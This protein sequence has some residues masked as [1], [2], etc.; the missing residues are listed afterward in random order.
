MNGAVRVQHLGKAYALVKPG[1]RTWW[2]VLRG[3]PQDDAQRRWVLRDVSFALRPG[4]SVGIIGVNGAGKSTLLKL[5]VGTSLPSQGEV[6]CHGRVV[7]M[8]E[9]G[10]GFHPEFSGREN[11]F[12]A[13]QLLGHSRQELQDRLQA[14]I[15][16]AELQ[17][18]I[19][20]PLRVYSSGMQMRLAFSVATALRP[21]VLIIDEALSVG[22]VAFQQKC[23]DRIRAFKQ[24]G[25]TL[26]LVSHDKNAVTQVCDRVLL[27]NHGAVVFDG[28]PVPAFDLYNALLAQHQQDHQVPQE[29]LSAGRGLVSGTGEAV[30]QQAR[31]CDA[32][33]GEVLKVV[34]VGQPVR[35]ELNIAVRAPIDRLVVGMGLKDRLGQVVY[36]TN[37]HYLQTPLGP[38]QAGDQLRLAFV[39]DMQLGA[40]DYTVQ[41]ALTASEHHLERNYEWNAA[42]L[43]LTVVNPGPG[44]FEGVAHLDAR[45]QRL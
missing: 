33:S 42:I 5:L 18:S 9:L 17:A 14:I 28:D 16:F 34:R 35:L 3:Q 45:L 36:G 7:A 21:D 8:L 44:L 25:T 10:F 30:V 19:D 38:C 13:G 24:A 43:T 26:L 6:Q 20:E 32:A 23:F 31:L 11:I 15:D 2:R 29:Q 39:F 1:A 12:L 40:G 37:T 4:E 41:T 27:L 22:D